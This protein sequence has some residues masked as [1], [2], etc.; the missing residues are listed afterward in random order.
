M[1]QYSVMCTISSSRTSPTPA[2]TMR[3]LRPVAGGPGM[4]PVRTPVIIHSVANP[5]PS[6]STLVFSIASSV[7]M[8][9]NAFVHSRIASRPCARRPVPASVNWPSGAK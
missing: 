5:V 4:S 3:K 6:L 2:P 9:M 1:F 8:A 7:Y